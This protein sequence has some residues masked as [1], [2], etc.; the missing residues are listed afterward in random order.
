VP[1]SI[2]SEKLTQHSPNGTSVGT[3]FGPT[4]ICTGPGLNPQ[5]AP[6]A[7]KTQ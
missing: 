2:E 6:D 1:S 7:L 4:R 5:V 3:G